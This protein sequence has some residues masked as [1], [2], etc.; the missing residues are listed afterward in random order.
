MIAIGFA[1]GTFSDDASE[2]FAAD[3]ESVLELYY[4]VSLTPWVAVS[5]SIQYVSHPGGDRDVD[6]AVV[7]GARAQVNF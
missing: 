2:L 3:R 5:P 4:N 1:Q 7:V 6:N